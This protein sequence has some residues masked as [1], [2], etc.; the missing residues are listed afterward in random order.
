MI[1]LFKVFMSPEVDDPI[2]EVLRSGYIGQGPKVEEFEKLL[3]EWLNVP[4]ALTIN[5]ATSGLQLAVHL[6]GTGPGSK[7]V[8]T[9][10]TC[11]ATNTAIV[12]NRTD[13][14]WADIDSD[15]GNI[16]IE[17]VDRALR[18]KMSGNNIKAIIAVDWAGY[19]CDYVELREL[20]DKYGVKIIRDAAHAFGSTY[21]QEK[22]GDWADYTVYSFQA[23]K[24][25]T[26]GDG[27]VLVC[28]SEPEH[29]RA[30]LLRWYGLDR[31]TKSDFRCSQDIPEA[32]FKYHMN[33]IN[34]TIGIAN[35][36]TIDERVGIHKANGE[37]YDEVLQGVPGITLLNRSGI[38][39][40]AHWIYTLLAEDREYLSRKLTA[41]DIMTS[42]V[43]R[44]NDEFGVFKKYDRY[45][46]PGLEE[47]SRNHIS[48]PCGWWVTQD[49]RE[50]IVTSIKEIM[51]E[52]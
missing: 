37:Y 40:S 31:E 19:P 20:A 17:S 28:R 2:C 1:P 38:K 12:A 34:A 21:A 6:A 11:S 23:I 29:A 52:Y 9:P 4:N 18:T 13:I 47:F 46:L 33:D 50:Y 7:I 26:T 10:M 48:I 41:R 36:A 16:S 39:E 51:E 15:T 30:K 35:M 45:I 32:G 25:L 24:H 27:G 22:V 44:R 14:V 42:Q 49:D 43:H 8:S 3:R 5:S